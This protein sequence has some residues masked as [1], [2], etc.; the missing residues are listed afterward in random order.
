MTLQLINSSTSL[1]AKQRVL[2]FANQLGIAE[3]I[4]IIGPFLRHDIPGLLINSD[5][6]ALARPN[7]IQAE[8]G[9]PTK[10]GEYL[11]TGN[12]VVVSNVGEINHFL[13]DGLNAFVSEPDDAKKFAKKL[14]E[15][16][17]SDKAEQIG[18]EG[19]KLV[20]KEFNYLVQAKELERFFFVNRP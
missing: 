4:Q 19:K 8:G 6:L 14:Q 11:A 13:K 12:P 20:Y 1:D 10:L 17:I 9:F 5:I 18:N 15:A 16:I 3:K 7:N 2:S